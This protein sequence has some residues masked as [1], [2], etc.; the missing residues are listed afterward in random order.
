MNKTEP[1][2]IVFHDTDTDEQASFDITPG[3]YDEF[4]VAGVL[5]HEADQPKDRRQHVEAG[6]ATYRQSTP[7]RKVQLLELSLERHKDNLASLESTLRYFERKKDLALTPIDQEENQRSIEKMKPALER[8]REVIGEAEGFLRAIKE[9]KVAHLAE[10]AEASGKPFQGETLH[11]LPSISSTLFHETQKIIATGSESFKDPNEE[12]RWHHAPIKR[13]NVHALALMRPTEKDLRDP[14]EFLDEES[15]RLWQERMGAE[16]KKLN[17]ET[18]DVLDGIISI[19]LDKVRDP[20]DGVWVKT[21]ELLRL[22][23]IRP[24]RKRGFKSEDKKRVALNIHRLSRLFIRVYEAE[25]EEVVMREGRKRTVLRR[26]QVEDNDTGKR[27]VESAI[28]HVGGRAGTELLWG[29]VEYDAW[30]ISLGP[31]LAPYLLGPGRQVALLSRKALEF[32]PIRQKFE[33]RLTR[34]LSWV[35]RIRAASGDILKPFKVRTLYEE[36]KLQDMKRKPGMRMARM[37]KA[38]DTLQDAGIIASWQY[39]DGYNPDGNFERWSNTDVYIEPAEIHKTQAEKIALPEGKPKATIPTCTFDHARLRTF[40][41]N[42]NLTQLQA[43]EE[44]QIM[45]DKRRVKSPLSRPLY[46]LV[47]GGKRKPSAPLE[48]ILADWVDGKV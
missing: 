9:G 41:R 37:E 23:G 48:K 13:K 39:E 26:G 21:K 36:V 11:Y 24:H 31:Q 25:W 2:R 3:M 1:W 47:E 42:R 46:A 5:Y 6:L 43:V 22:R 30:F 28:L 7:E 35:W 16:V 38:L 29:E 10:A 33:K 40:R 34:Y 44:L 18:A 32:D 20:R 27:F 4:V 15:I 45:L 8:T 19:Y 12:H 17:D 14:E